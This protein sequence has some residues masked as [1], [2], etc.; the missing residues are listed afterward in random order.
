MSETRRISGIRWTRERA[1]FL[2]AGCLLAGIAGGWMIHGSRLEASA[3]VS[4]AVPTPSAAAPQPSEPAQ[5]KEM[6]D[7]QAAPLLAR[8]KSDP[9]NPDL[10]TNVGNLYYDAQQYETA[11][12]YY[13]R[14]L[15]GRPADASVRTDMGT[16]FWY[17]G[18][19]DRAIEEF[20]KA[21]IYVPNNSNTLFNLGLV[22]WKGKQDAASAT[23]AWKKLLSADPNYEQKDQVKKML[24][25]VQQHEADRLSGKP[26]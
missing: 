2:A 26:N 18:N 21:L 16:A 15:K 13:A 6:A 10:L 12:D 4:V 5:M 25:E 7:A 20:N 3:A 22:K 19:P 14:A 9:G 24:A 23:A 11:V 17:M 1:A 8:L